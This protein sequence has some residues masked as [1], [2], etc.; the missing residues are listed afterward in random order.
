MATMY[1]DARLLQPHARLPEAS[2]DAWAGALG[3]L[4]ALHAQHDD[5]YLPWI[6]R[7]AMRWRAHARS[8]AQL[9]DF[10]E[11]LCAQTALACVPAIEDELRRQAQLSG[12]PWHRTL[13][14]HASSGAALPGW[15]VYRQE[16]AGSEDGALAEQAPELPHA[17]LL[18][19]SLPLRL[20]GDPET[21]PTG[22]KD[23]YA[24]L[25]A[26]A[27]G[28]A[29]TPGADAATLE[30]LATRM[31]HQVVAAQ[32]HEIE[33]QVAQ[34]MAF[35]DFADVPDRRERHRL[36]A[37]SLAQRTGVPS[38]IRSRDV[39]EQDFGQWVDS[40]TVGAEHQS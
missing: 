18:V 32:P 21:S 6:P 4:A 15:S 23:G 10:H 2:D 3:T 31:A 33:A 8:S 35:L 26:H 38:R 24:R 12:R 17:V 28:L 30:A 11:A 34:V 13:S 29:S 19:G 5:W 14:V 22:L 9:I 16:T 20:R 1:T 25:H 7:L 36:V 27:A 40:E 37:R 39:G